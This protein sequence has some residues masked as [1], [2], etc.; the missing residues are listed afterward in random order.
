MHLHNDYAKFTQNVMQ[1]LCKIGA[2]C[3]RSEW[4]HLSVVTLAP[5]AVTGACPPMTL[6]LLFRRIVGEARPYLVAKR[7]AD[8]LRMTA[9]NVRRR[10]ACT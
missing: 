2:L 10:A 7:R 6:W 4:T 1:S 5:L 3:I 8:W 9:R